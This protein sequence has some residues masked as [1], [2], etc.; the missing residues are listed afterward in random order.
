MVK[1][2]CIDQVIATY[3]ESMSYTWEVYYVT[4][5]R[6]LKWIF[7]I[8]MRRDKLSRITPTTFLSVADCKCYD[9]RTTNVSCYVRVIH[10]NAVHWSML[11]VELSY[12][13]VKPP[14]PLRKQITAM[15]KARQK[16][17]K[18]MA[19]P[20]NKHCKSNA[21][22]VCS[23]TVSHSFREQIVLEKECLDVAKSFGQQIVAW[24]HYFEVGRKT[25]VQTR[26][27][28]LPNR[29]FY[30]PSLV[31]ISNLEC[32]FLTQDFTSSW[33]NKISLPWTTANI[34]CSYVKHKFV[35]ASFL[36]VYQL[37]KERT[38]RKIRTHNIN[39]LAKLKVRR[40]Q[41]SHFVKL[42]PS[43]E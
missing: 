6:Y 38:E 22:A 31:F 18:S 42:S 5:P 7:F 2:R 4:R 3:V 15:V 25:Y 13:L 36:N 17:C 30:L 9:I 27:L 11:P 33:N 21:K 14:H 20:D 32:H 8:H 40:L 37:I 41:N 39:I 24:K 12:S 29:E 1:A 23:T 28:S 34:T 16:Q 19:N 10:W 35:T 43:E 26:T